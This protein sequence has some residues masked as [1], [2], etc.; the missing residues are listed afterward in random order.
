MKTIVISQLPHLCIKPRQHKKPVGLRYITSGSGSSL[1][2]LSV[3]LSI[4]LKSMLHSAKNRSIYDNK[5]RV[6]NEP[7]LDFLS[8]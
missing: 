3:Y 1:Q 4:C 5:F 8:Y 7:I 2:Q 6:Y